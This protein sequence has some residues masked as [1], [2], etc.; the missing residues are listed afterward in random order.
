[1][2]ALREALLWTGGPQLDR[3]VLISLLVFG[4]TFFHFDEGAL[5]YP[6]YCA[7]LTVA[8]LLVSWPVV[9]HCVQSR[10]EYAPMAFAV[11]GFIALF[12]SHYF[13]DGGAPP[14]SCA[15][16]LI[17][18]GLLILAMC[19]AES[20]GLT[21]FVE[22][23]FFVGAAMLT[24][25]VVIA[26][27]VTGPIPEDSPYY[28]IHQPGY[29]IVFAALFAFERR[30]WKLLSV[31]A[32][33][34]GLVLVARP[35]STLVIDAAVAC[36][37]AAGYRLF[38]MR[39]GAWF[40]AAVI[41]S[42]ATVS[43]AALLNPEILS[44]FGSIEEELKEGVLGSES[45]SNTRVAIIQAAHDE[46]ETSSLVFG[47]FFL[48]GTNPDFGYLLGRED[49]TAPIHS[50]FIAI[51]RQGGL[52]GL[53]V[54]SAFLVFLVAPRGTRDPDAMRAAGACIVV[55][56]VSISFNPILAQIEHSIWFLLLAYFIMQQGKSAQRERTQP[57]A[58]S[59]PDRSSASVRT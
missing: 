57:V 10:F 5:A 33:L 49:F 7:W 37:S 6:K 46:F 18:F 50:D 42:L 27:L 8:G 15:A 2:R 51:M 22:S 56:C 45:N 12:S 23:W 36:A 32:I 39:R 52:V 41:V 29:V 59:S 25:Q 58:I 24:A 54:F 13:N 34:L 31:A 55:F 4:S 11:I 40:A 16:L 38:G 44:T 30:Q 35:S 53:G 1:M 17:P 19:H 20:D 21:G 14:S 9:P 26:R 48:A 47:D 3:V 43:A 28:Q